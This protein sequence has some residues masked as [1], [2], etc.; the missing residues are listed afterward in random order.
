M[1]KIFNKYLYIPKNGK[2]S[3]NVFKTR[4][5]LSFLTM[6]FCLVLLASTTY[7]YF[8]ATAA[9]TGNQIVAGNFSIKIEC[10]S[11]N[12]LIDPEGANKNKYSLDVGTYIFTLKPN[13]T[14]FNGFALVNMGDTQYITAAIGN[15]LVF[16]VRAGKRMDLTFTPHWGNSA[17]YQNLDADD[18]LAASGSLIYIKAVNTT[19]SEV[20][21][22]DMAARADEMDATV[23]YVE[24]PAATDLSHLSAGDVRVVANDANATVETPVPADEGHTWTVTVTA[25]DKKTTTTYTIK[26]ALADT[27][28]SGQLTEPTQTTQPTQTTEPPTAPEPASDPS[29]ETKP[30][31][32]E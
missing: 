23:Y 14:A 3:E 11:D 32:T 1:N 2:I 27:D 28:T 26:L 22:K 29:S 21:V 5:L 9:S 17:D 15:E 6:L 25:E 12:N 16:E 7:A 20:K 19:V 18:I 13:G 30:E 24:L 8:T 31:P 4:M 10:R